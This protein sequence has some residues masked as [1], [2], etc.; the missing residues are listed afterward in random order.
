MKIWQCKIGEIQDAALHA[1]YPNGADSPMRH[2]IRA[3][4]VALTG[5]E[6]QFIFSGWAAKLTD[7]ERDCVNDVPIDESLAIRRLRLETDAQ[8]LQ[9]LGTDGRKWAA[10]FKERFGNQSEL[11]EEALVGWFANA[12]EAGADR[13]RYL[14]IR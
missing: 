2:A 7:G 8:L 6:P 11:D 12:I 14:R 3:A 1:R 13:E 10:E 5:Q 9:R 4:Y